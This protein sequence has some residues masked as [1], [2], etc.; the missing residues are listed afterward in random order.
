M[1]GKELVA[2]DALRDWTCAGCGGT[3][4][5]LVMEDRGPICLACADLDHLV[6]L[7]RGDAAL[8]R[9]ARRE[10]GLSAVVVRFSRAR[11]R[12]ERQGVLVEEEAL[13]RAEAECLADA[14]ARERRR[15]RDQQ[16]R[17]NEDRVLEAELTREIGR[18]FPGCPA[19]RAAAIARHTSL[20]SS[21]RVG[22]TGAGRNLDP[23]AV[24]LAVIASIRHEDT[25]YDELLMESGDACAGASAGPARRRRRARTMAD[26][27][28]GDA[29]IAPGGRATRP[30]GV[31]RDRLREPSG[32]AT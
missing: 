31:G 24:T 2:V 9:R 18:L 1:Q 13:A 23:E 20:R 25:G 15:V 26:R 28:A 10:S 17:A 32:S 6:F 5:L 3:D 19:G 8:T 29:V 11:R 30:R 22:R 14:D 12:Y 7:P 16:R 4:W 21:G 27:V